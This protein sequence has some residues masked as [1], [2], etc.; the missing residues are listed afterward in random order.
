MGTNYYLRRKQPTIRET[1]H[2]CKRSFGWRTSWQETRG[3]DWPRWCDEDHSTDEDGNLVVDRKLPHEIRGVEDIRAYL[4]TGEWELVDEY[5][6]AY[7]DWEAEIADLVA[8]DG[9]KAAY[10]ARNPDRPVTWD[11]REHEWGSYHDR[12]GNV[13][14]REGFC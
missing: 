7:P 2:V 12:E 14:L 10:N 4:R 8:W 5:G 6:E 1:I 3:D 13:M 11:A 9:G